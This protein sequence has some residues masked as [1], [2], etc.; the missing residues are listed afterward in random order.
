MAAW[1]F[2]EMR[3]SVKKIAFVLN[4]PAVI[5]FPAKDRDATF[6]LNNPKGI[7][8]LSPGLRGTSYPGDYDKIRKTL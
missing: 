2:N 4:N 3:D 1:R 6:L 5:E 8:S 7:E